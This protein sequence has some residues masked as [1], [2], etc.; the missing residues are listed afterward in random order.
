M[1]PQHSNTSRV[2]PVGARRLSLAL[3]VAGSLGISNTVLPALPV[4]ANGHNP[5]SLSP[6]SNQWSAQ[7][8][9]FQNGSNGL[10]VHNV[11]SFHNA[12]AVHG[13][14]SIHAASTVHNLSSMH[15][16]HSVGGAFGQLWQSKN[17]EDFGHGHSPAYTSI[18]NSSPVGTGD[19][20]LSSAAANIS[21]ANLAGFHELTIIVGGVKQVVGVDTK[22]TGAEAI[23]A[24][25]VL[26]GGRQ[27]ITV[28]ADGRAVGGSI[29]LSG[30]M[31]SAIDSALGGGINTLT[32]SHG[33]KVIDT[34]SSL[35]L[36]GNLDN[37][38]SIFTASTTRNAVD[39]ISA[40]AI[41]NA[42]GAYIGSYS[43][44]TPGLYAAD[45]SLRATTSITNTGTIYSA[46]NLYLSAPLTDNTN[47]LLAA[48]NN[49]NYAAIGQAITISGGDI[50]S[51]E[52]N[53][54]AG[55][56]AVEI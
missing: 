36:S 7:F 54:R 52:L 11:S 33:V 43:G 28:S 16:A 46:H 15:S 35:V 6:L 49:I 24:Q 40:D 26:A 22:L 31:L 38:G 13:A 21:A 44:N 14:S 18:H 30:A 51:R 10:A 12:S 39:T 29:L 48:K 19:L 37:H 17:F 5:S 56:S 42:A 1:K 23:A 53:V 9:P 47:G 50:L 45:P 20:N 27:T 2:G 3:G 32:I 34:V 4:L 41:I 8:S 25:Q 55:Q